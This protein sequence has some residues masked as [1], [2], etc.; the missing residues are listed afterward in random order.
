MPPNF[1]YS[2]KEVKENQVRVS[3]RDVRVSFKDSVE[4]CRAVKGMKLD[5]ARN[6]L[7]DVVNGRR[8][9]PF[10]RYKKHVGHRNDLQGWPAGR[11][12]KK[13]ASKILELLDHGEAMAEDKGLDIESLYIVHLA[14]QQGPKLRRYFPRAYGRATPK[15]EQLVHFELVLEE[16]THE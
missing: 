9:I 13:I 14:A 4:V 10:K 7:R 8:S 15:I 2:Y 12:P 16:R 1:G 11:Y 5:D 6:L 3:F